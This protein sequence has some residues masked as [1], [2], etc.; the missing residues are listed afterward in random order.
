[1]VIPYYYERTIQNRQQMVAAFMHADS[2][3]PVL[4]DPLIGSTDDRAGQLSDVTKAS[5]F[6]GHTPDDL[7]EFWMLAGGVP[8]EQTVHQ[9]EETTL[10]GDL[11]VRDSPNLLG[12]QAKSDGNFPLQI[13]VFEVTERQPLQVCA[14]PEGRRV[15]NSL[16]WFSLSTPGDARVAVG[17]QHRVT[18][19]Q[20][21][22]SIESAGLW[23]LLRVFPAPA[24][25]A[26]FMAPGVV[27]AAD[28]GCVLM[29]IAHPS[30]ARRT[31]S[32]WRAAAE[33]AA[34]AIQQIRFAD[35]AASRIR[36]DVQ[37]MDRTRKIPLVNISPDFDV[38]ELR[39]IDYFFGRTDGS[40][41]HVLCPLGRAVVVET[42]GGSVEA[43]PMSVC[44]VPARGGD[45]HVK[46]GGEP[47]KVL[48]ITP[49][50]VFG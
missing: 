5:G 50:S 32:S 37:P 38:D 16:F 21:M 7:A 40:A 41:P 28:R 48:R 4:V 46:G 42:S 44:V 19:G 23:E 31:V 27:F 14:S 8:H 18:R 26:F 12:R 6:G 2:S 22:Q 15:G 20:F 24:G 49:K 13:R 11:I 39:V 30:V 25:D 3:T 9:G 33:D 43:P 35:R 45:Y 17:I 47:A 29:E 36:K 34:H 1:M 10:L